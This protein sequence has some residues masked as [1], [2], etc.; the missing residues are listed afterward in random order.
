MGRKV[1]VS[2]EHRWAV[3]IALGIVLWWLRDLP[4]RQAS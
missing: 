3:L 4:R 1:T 2:G